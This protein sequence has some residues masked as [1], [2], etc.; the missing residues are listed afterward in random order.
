MLREFAQHR[1]GY[2]YAAIL[3][4]SLV[5]TR[6]GM[7]PQQRLIPCRGA[8]VDDA[9]TALF[10]TSHGTHILFPEEALVSPS[11]NLIDQLRRAGEKVALTGL[12]IDKLKYVGAQELTW[13]L[14]LDVPARLQYLNDE[15][16]VEALADVESLQRGGHARIASRREPRLD[17][18]QNLP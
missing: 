13:D 18:N 12:D 15:Q 11:Q 10:L 16:I 4:R 1:L 5:E 2:C 9:G 14:H 6:G 8:M 3:Y 17:P 7:L